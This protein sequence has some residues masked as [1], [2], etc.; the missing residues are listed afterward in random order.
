MT[1]AAA[2]SASRGT[3]LVLDVA[4]ASVA[5]AEGTALG[6]A[7]APVGV[8]QLANTRELCYTAPGGTPLCAWDLPSFTAALV[9]ALLAALAPPGAVAGAPGTVGGAVLDLAAVVDLGALINNPQ[10][11]STNETAVA[12]LR[13]RLLSAV[14]D[15][16]IAGGSSG[17]SADGIAAVAAVLNISIAKAT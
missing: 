15:L 5:A 9:S 2:T 6:A 1:L 14:G 7:L 4:V 13:L 3:L 17:V 16:V 8:T 12:S 10:A 11:D